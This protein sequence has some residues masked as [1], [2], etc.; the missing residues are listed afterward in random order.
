[1]PRP[2]V[3]VSNAARQRA[4]RK[5]KAE[6]RAEA[7]LP[8]SEGLRGSVEIERQFSRLRCLLTDFP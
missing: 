4:Y 5:A 3:H 8:S 1:M 2:K 6:S 7:S